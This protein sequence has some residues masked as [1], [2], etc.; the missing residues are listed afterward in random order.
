LEKGVQENK[1][2][3]AVESSGGISA[4]FHILEK[5]GYLP[6][7]L[8][9]GILADTGQKLSELKT[10]LAKKYG[11]YYFKEDKYE[12]EATKK[13]A[14]V[15]FFREITKENLK[16]KFKDPISLIN[17]TDGVKVEFENGDWFLF[18]LSGTEPMARVYAE[19]QSEQQSDELVKQAKQI[20]T[21]F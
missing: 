16:T 14:L 10:E 4:S 9:M 15:N 3:L 20:I 11:K 17:K 8:L 12:F 13:V 5:C 21:F 19:T 18:R 7:V 1:I 2:A 6:G